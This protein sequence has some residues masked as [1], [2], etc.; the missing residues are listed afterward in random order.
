LVIRAAAFEPRVQRVI[1]Y[2]DLTDVLET[3]LRNFPASIGEQV[4]GWLE[5]DNENA[6]NAFFEQARSQS[7]LLDWM[8]K[9]A[10]HVTGTQTVFEALRHFQ[11]FETASISPKV[12]QDV[13]LLAGSEDHYVP[14]HQLPDQ[15]ATLTHVRSCCLSDK[16]DLTQVC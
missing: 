10:N 13:L 1:A 14:I 5:S 11:R 3:N 2:D 16:T 12:T 6:L 7:L 8:L 4:R 9:Q 15:I